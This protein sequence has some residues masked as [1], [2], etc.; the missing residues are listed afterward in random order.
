L[1]INETAYKAFLHC[2]STTQEWQKPHSSWHALT[3]TVK[4]KVFQTTWTRVDAVLHPDESIL[5]LA[6]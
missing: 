4:L 2:F 1:E 5:G 3:E 6:D